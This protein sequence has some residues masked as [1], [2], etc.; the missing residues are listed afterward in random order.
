[1]DDESQL[2]VNRYGTKLWENKL[3]EYHHINGPAIEYISGSNEWYLRGRRHRIDGPAASL[4]NGY[5]LW[6]KNGVLFKNKDD[7]FE[8]LTDEEKS[9]ALF[10]EDFLNG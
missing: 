10:S 5:K 6:Y 1:M 3:G 2:S 4:S 7:F 9:I 8:S